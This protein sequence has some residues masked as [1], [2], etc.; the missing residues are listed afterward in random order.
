MTP[1]EIVVNRL[2]EIS[3]RKNS[4]SREKTCSQCG[5]CC[6]ITICGIGE[7]LIGD[8]FLPPCPLLEKV[9]GK[10]LC[11]AVLYSNIVFPGV[12]DF[13]ALALGIGLGCCNAEKV[14][15]IKDF[16]PFMGATNAST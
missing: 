15:F 9:G 5:D 11:G 6:S 8:D 3:A 13:W 1:K 4:T 7:L 2:K 14:G 16:K 12:G 10:K